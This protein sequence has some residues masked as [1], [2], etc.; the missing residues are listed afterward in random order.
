MVSDSLS[1]RDA[2]V[3]VGRRK[4]LF[5]DRRH[6]AHLVARLLERDAAL[7]ASD[8][9]ERVVAAV[10]LSSIDH[11]GKKD[12]SACSRA[13]LRSSDL[14]ER[15]GHDANDLMAFAV[16]RDRAPDDVEVAAKPAPPERFAQHDDAGTG[17]LLV[18]R[19]ERPPGDR[20]DP[21]DAKERRRHKAAAQLLRLPIVRYR[22]GCRCGRRRSPRSSSSAP[23][24]KDS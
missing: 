17:R 8:D 7:Q 6:R 10:L 4:L 20:R 23:P 11:H 13:D 3:G 9:A 15:P 21:Q 16:E 18:F 22:H 14:A 19:P 2:P 5:H 12:L 24:R 1:M